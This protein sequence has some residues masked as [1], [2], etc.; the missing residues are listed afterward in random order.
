MRAYI[1]N[2]EADAHIHTYLKPIKTVGPI[3]PKSLNLST[4][5][6]KLDPEGSLVIWTL[7]YKA[8]ISQFAILTRPERD[9][10]DSFKSG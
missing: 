3:N 4:G 2:C 8:G 5:W 7:S 1:G 10:S 6:K 9:S